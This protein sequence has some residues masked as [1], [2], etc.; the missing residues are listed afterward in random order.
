MVA[1]VGRGGWGAA[2]GIPGGRH[3]APSAR[4]HFVVHWPGGSVGADERQMVRNIDSSHARQG[5]AVVGYNF[6]VGQS[7]TIYEGAGRDVRGIHEASRNTDGW[8]CCVM[9]AV[10]TQPS[11]AALNATRALYDHLCG[12]AGRRLEMSVHNR[13]FATQCAGPSLTAWVRGGMGGTAPPPPPAVNVPNAPPGTPPWPGRILRQPPIMAGA[14]VRTW[15]GHPGSGL[16]VDGAYG[17]RSEA[18]CRAVQ[19]AAG[20]G[21]DGRVGPNTWPASWRVGGGG[22][23]PPAAA[24]GAPPF[25]GRILINR[26]PMMQGTDVR[27]WQE[28]ARNIAADGVYGPRSEARCREIQRQMGLPVDG[29]VGPNTWPATWRS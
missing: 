15:Q 27:T 22:G 20:L 24:G 6:L 14:D 19:Q 17:P 5:W 28:R 2:R 25:P 13:W 23:A 1:I 21:V 4:R 8:G 3:V 7:G 11:Q 12:V 26:H 18:R 9:H 10:G 29:R 16:A